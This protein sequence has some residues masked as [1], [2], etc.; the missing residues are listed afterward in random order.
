MTVPYF[1]SAR[2]RAAA[3]VF[4]ISIMFVTGPVPPGTGVIAPATVSAEADTLTI[5][6]PDN[7]GPAAIDTYHDHRMAMSFALAG[8]RA[9]GI[10]IRNTECVTKTYPAFFQD[11]QK[12]LSSR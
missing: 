8:T 1:S 4:R 3:S 9:P 10:T 7:L 11:L 6:P 5:D 2:A 12:V